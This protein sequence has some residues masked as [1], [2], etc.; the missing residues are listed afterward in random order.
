MRFHTSDLVPVAHMIGTVLLLWRPA[1]ERWGRWGAAQARCSLWFHDERGPRVARCLCA[2]R[3]VVAL[4]AD[5]RYRKDRTNG[6]LTR[7]AL[8]TSTLI[9][10]HSRCVS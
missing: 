5:G 4:S 9:L 6:A 10:A 1:G 3:A 7:V 2:G 8:P